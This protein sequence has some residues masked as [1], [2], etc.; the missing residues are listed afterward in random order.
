MFSLTAY[1]TKESKIH[2]H[3]HAIQ[4]FFEQTEITKLSNLVSRQLMV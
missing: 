2:T 4:S 3:M 1:T